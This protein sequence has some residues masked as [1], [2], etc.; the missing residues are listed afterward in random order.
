MGSR[1]CGRKA[2]K[3]A[4]GQTENCRVE[5]KDKFKIWGLSPKNFVLLTNGGVY[6]IVRDVDFGQQKMGEF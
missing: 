2:G 5:E 4:G 1:E 6:G 3:A